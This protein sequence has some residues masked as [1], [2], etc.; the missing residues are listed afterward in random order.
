MAIVTLPLASESAS[1]QFAGLM[2]FSRTL[3]K[4]RCR[5]LV[6]PANPMTQDQQDT[7]NAMRVSAKVVKWANTTALKA[8]TETLTDKARINA[9]RGS[10]RLWNT[11]LTQAIVGEQMVNYG[12]AVAA[13]TVLTA[14]QKAAWVAAAEALVPEIPAVVQVDA[15]GVAGTPI[16]AGQAFFT[17]VYG[18]YTLGLSTE[19]T[20]TPPTYA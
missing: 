7:R 16:T 3:G 1:G 18:L 15:D 11:T 2:V 17:Y 4:N 13:Y 6:T 10:N 12:A 20:G 14:P 9:I 5:Q 19:P 8:P